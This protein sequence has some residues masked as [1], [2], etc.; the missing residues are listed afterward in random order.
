[1]CSKSTTKTPEQRHW[2]L[3]GVFI[4]NFEHVNVGW[5]INILKDSYS[6]KRCFQ[7]T[8]WLFSQKYPGP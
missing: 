6:Q 3:F 1:M 8:Y 7:F 5:V 2:R 4:A